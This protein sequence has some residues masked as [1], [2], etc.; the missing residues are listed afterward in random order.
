LFERALATQLIGTNGVV[1]SDRVEI[2]AR[3]A[4]MLPLV[5]HVVADVAVRLP[6]FVDRD[7]LVSA[8]MLGLTQAAHT[9]DASRG[10]SF[11]AFAR[12]RIRGAVLDELRGR[13]PLSRGA[14]RR[15]NQVHAA[16]AALQG[17]LGRAPTDAETAEH[18]GVDVTAVR[19]AHADVARA[20]QLERSSGDLEATDLTE[21]VDSAEGGPLAELLD[22]ELRGYLMDAVAVLPDR[23]RIIVVAH[24]FDG[25]EMQ[26]IAAELGVTASRVSQ[27]CGR[28]VSLLRDGLNAQLDP[29][30]VEDLAETTSRVARRKQA[31]YQM[32]A[33]S[34]SVGERLARGRAAEAPVPAVAAVAAAA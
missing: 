30:R 16:A 29:E 12:L 28:A 4:A 3:V 25:R 2:D 8:G 24:F 20:T 15:A 22:A 1:A 14:R 17:A 33:G 23:L 21:Q 11:Q 19:Q 10:V 27:L 6:R 9:Y 34:S 5:R 32:V 18:L 13:D 26:D 7:E 31:Y